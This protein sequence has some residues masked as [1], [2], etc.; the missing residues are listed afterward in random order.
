VIVLLESLMLQWIAE[1]HNLLIAVQLLIAIGELRNCVE[2]SDY[3]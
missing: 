3:F 1:A 2:L